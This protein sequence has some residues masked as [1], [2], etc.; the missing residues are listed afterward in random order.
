MMSP[1]TNAPARL[2][3]SNGAR[4]QREFVSL[5]GLLTVEQWAALPD[6]KPR[7]ELIEG[8]LV[9]KMTTTNAHAFAAGNFLIECA[10][11]GRPRGWL[12]LPEG[13]GVKTDE[14]NGAVP[15]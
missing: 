11:W 8:K 9:Q 13:T 2:K 14:Y 3:K 7:Y 10:L 5:D 6:T 12:F 4:R 15:D 1:I